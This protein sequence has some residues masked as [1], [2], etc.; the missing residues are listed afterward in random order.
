MVMVPSSRFLKDTRGAQTP[1]AG[2]SLYSWPRSTNFSVCAAVARTRSCGSA[3]WLPIS[4][5]V[6]APAA[7]TTVPA[8]MAVPSASLMPLVTPFSTMRSF[9]TGE[10]SR[11]LTPRSSAALA[12][13]SVAL[14]GSADPSLGVQ[15]PPIHVPARPGKSSFTSLSSNIRVSRPHTAAWGIHFLNW[16]YRFSL[17]QRARLPAACHPTEYP[18]SASMTRQRFMDSRISSSSRRSL[19]CCLQKPQ[20]FDDCEAAM[21]L[22]S[23]TVTLAPLKARW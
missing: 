19:P 12:K 15:T 20:D 3:K 22:V 8:C 6:H 1:M 5:E 13:A 14:A 7:T 23:T 11:K 17:S 4:S 10:N 2:K 9:T 18:N 21:P 16:L